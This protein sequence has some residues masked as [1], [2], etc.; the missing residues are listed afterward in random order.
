MVSCCNRRLYKGN[1]Y[2][3]CLPITDTGVTSVS[4]YTSGDIV[5]EKEGEIVDDT[6]CFEL[7]KKEL[8]LLPDGVLRYSYE[9][10]DSNTEYVVATPGDY[11]GTTLDDLLEDAFDSGYTAGQEYCSGDTCEGVFESGYTSGYTD[12]VNSVV[13]SGYTQED[14]DA[15]FES[16]YTAGQ[17]NCSGATPEELHEAYTSGFTLGRDTCNFIEAVYDVKSTTEPT[18]VPGVG[19]ARFKRGILSDGTVMKPVSYNS[20]M[21]YVFPSSGLQ[22]VYYELGNYWTDWT[23]AFIECE[24]LVSI[25]IPDGVTRLGNN[26]FKGCK[27]LT[28]IT[29][30]ESVTGIGYDAISS[31]DS[32]SSITIPDS[33]VDMS[34]NPMR[35]NPALTTVNFGSGMTYVPS[36]CFFGDTSLTGFTIPPTVTV[37]CGSCFSSCESLSSIT[38]PD[39]VTSMGGTCFFGCRNLSEVTYSTGMTEIPEWTFIGCNLSQFEI[40]DTIVKI[41]DIALKDNPLTSLVIPSGVTEFGEMVLDNCSALTSVT[42]TS[43]VP[44]TFGNLPLGPTRYRYPIYVPCQSVD[45][46]KA[47]LPD[48]AERITCNSEP[49]PQSAATAITITVPQ[50]LEPGDTGSTSVSASPTGATTNLSY[51]S[52]DNSV[53]TVDNNGNITAVGTGTTNICVTDSISQISACTQL[54]ITEPVY[55]GIALTFDVI[56]GGSIVWTANRSSYTPTIQYSKNGGS[57]WTN[58]TASTGGTSISVNAGDKVLFRGNNPSYKVDTYE[59]AHFYHTTAVF[60]LEGNIMSLVNSK[61]YSTATTVSEYAFYRLFWH[62]DGLKSAENLVLPATTLATG[63]YENMFSLCRGLTKAPKLPATSIAANCYQHMFSNC[64]SLAIAPELPATTLAEGCY[65]CMFS[66][67]TSLSAAPELNAPT[68]EKNCYECMFN[69]CT[70]LNYV[71]CLAYDEIIVAS[72]V[73]NW[74][75]NVAQYGTFVKDPRMQVGQT[76]SGRYWLR[77]DGGIPTNW[78]VEDAQS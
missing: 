37:L 6:M 16:G 3:I 70:N 56:S 19:N 53:A 4:F 12:G 20:R 2:E 46:Y 27:S 42:F 21:G 45:A 5:I 69:G 57:S 74:L 18:V 41:G 33:V 28:G 65:W 43:T 64:S 67:C 15:A 26:A 32:L 63:C 30:P 52:S 51:S 50:D 61:G 35:N 9:D 59:Y 8:D 10:F 36:S 47:A 58:I 71:K 78:T 60:N 31:C 48:Y 76:M 1:S 77:G 17:D 38:I 23:Q 34:N 25:E 55:S 14:L 72:A 13:C 11:S 7:T 39:T 40:P 49:E 24:D 22:T 68:L 66:A 75:G 54:A 44:P 73:N 62:C 29:I